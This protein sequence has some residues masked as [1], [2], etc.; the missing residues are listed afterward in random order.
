MSNDKKLT[1]LL[2]G[3]K[4]AEITIHPDSCAIEMVDGGVLTVVGQIVKPAN[5]TALI[6]ATM[7]QASEEAPV[8]NLSVTLPSGQKD[9]IL[10]TMS[11]PGS[12]II[13]R[14]AFGVIT[15]AG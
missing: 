5:T 10:I 1:T 11:D 2:M 14:N 3:H 6:G 8:L 9:R 13:L 7:A 4:I 12:G 15:Y